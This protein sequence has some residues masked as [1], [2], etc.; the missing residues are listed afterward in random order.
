[1][2]QAIF[3]P[4]YQHGLVNLSCSLLKYYGLSSKHSSLPELDKILQ[5]KDYRTIILLVLDGMGIDML[6]HNLPQNSFL[7]SHFQTTISSVYPPTT[8]AATTSLYSGLTPLEHG[9]IGW[10]CYF[11]EYN[12]N[13]ELFRN[14]DF[15]TQE[16]IDGNVVKEFLNYD[17]LYTQIE[18][19]GVARGY[20]VAQ[21][22]GD[23]EIKDFDAICSNLLKLSRKE[24]RKFILSYWRQP[25]SVMHTTGCYSQETCSTMANLDIKLQAMNEKL[26]DTLLIITADHGLIDISKSTNLNEIVELEVCLRHPPAI[27]PRTMTFYIKPGYEEK[28]VA[29]FKKHFGEEYILLTKEEYLSQGYLGLGS[30]H[31]KVKDFVGDFIALAIGDSIIQYQTKGGV[32]PVEFKA[33]H[34]GLSRQ[35]M[36]VPLIICKN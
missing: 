14:L 16:K 19:F 27:E 23:F 6:A 17:K 20:G 3:K 9:H 35:E 29:G 13:I 24:E 21:P 11:E 10:Q 32:A 28:F 1:M 4:D 2:K 34:A 8:T 33:H 22:W 30:P 31:I 36:L 7:R 12:R 15:Y 25:D 5:Q 26:E 18:H